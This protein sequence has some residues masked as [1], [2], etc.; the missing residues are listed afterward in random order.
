MA[1][2]FMRRI[3]D[4]YFNKTLTVLALAFVAAIVVFGFG[5]H[6]PRTA[7]APLSGELAENAHVK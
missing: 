1:T 4:S 5:D 6:P 3:I 2:D 7:Y